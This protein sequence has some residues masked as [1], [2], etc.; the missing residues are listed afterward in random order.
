M[1][2]TAYKEE[3]L[4]NFYKGTFEGVHYY[5]K[6]IFIDVVEIK[7]ESCDLSGNSCRFSSILR[8]NLLFLP[9]NLYTFHDVEKVKENGKRAIQSMEKRALDM[10]L[11]RL[12]NDD[13]EW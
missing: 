12:V 8:C 11:K 9:K 4:L 13:F 1:Y 10:I 7:S 3:K 6:L 5:D 2:S